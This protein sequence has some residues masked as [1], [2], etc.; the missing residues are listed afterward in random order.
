MF[1]KLQ[2]PHLAPWDKKI[3]KES[4]FRSSIMFNKSMKSDIDAISAQSKVN[5]KKLN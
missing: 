1:Q 2:P 5:S 3:D 4:Y